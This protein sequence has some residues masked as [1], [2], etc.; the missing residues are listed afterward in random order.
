MTTE[1]SALNASSLQ[2]DWFYAR[3]YDDEMIG[4]SSMHQ[5]YKSLQ[6]SASCSDGSVLDLDPV[7]ICLCLKNLGNLE[8][9]ERSASGVSE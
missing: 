3:L 4:G 8:E 2:G 6:T 5:L 9:Q 7:R 1:H